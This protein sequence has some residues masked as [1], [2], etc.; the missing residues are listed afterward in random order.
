MELI[1]R[2]YLYILGVSKELLK[3]KQKAL[4]IEENMDK[5][6]FI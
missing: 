1:I 3:R 5:L 6:D 2:E 4:T